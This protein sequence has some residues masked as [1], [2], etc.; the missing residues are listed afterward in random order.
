MRT[1]PTEGPLD[2]K[3]DF[4]LQSFKSELFDYCFRKLY[5]AF[6]QQTFIGL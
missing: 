2:L 3:D 4:E 1:S 5:L 6:H